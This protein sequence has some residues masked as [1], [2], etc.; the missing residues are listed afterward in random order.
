MPASRRRICASSRR[1]GVG[2]VRRGSLDQRQPL[3]SR[4]RPRSTIGAPWSA[5]QAAG[6]GARGHGL[7]GS[8]RSGA[9]G[10]RGAA[11]RRPKRRRGSAAGCVRGSSAS[12]PRPSIR[13]Q[14]AH[15]VRR[16][17]GQ[18][19]GDTG[20]QRMAEQVEAVQ[21][22]A[23]RPRPAR[24]RRSRAGRSARRDRAAGAPS[25]H[26]RAGP[27]RSARC[28]G[29]SGASAREAGGVVQP[30]V[31]GQQRR[32]VVRA[33][34]AGLAARVRPRR[35][36][37]RSWLAQGVGALRARRPASR[38]HAVADRSPACIRASPAGG[39]APG[40]RAPPRARAR[41]FSAGM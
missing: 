15:A 24:R 27:A 34:H 36:R 37:A 1:T 2:R 38:L 41:S 12:G 7:V 14:P 16:G 6:G 3:P 25:G 26:G 4:A 19:A 18:Q 9:G 31:Q 35:V 23:H 10:A 33:V 40:R 29:S 22:P 5:A 17:G 32:G 21:R 39:A 28:A 8:R 20:A 13:T 11:A 30:A